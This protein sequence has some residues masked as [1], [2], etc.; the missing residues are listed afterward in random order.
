MAS[1][2]GWKVLRGSGKNLHQKRKESQP[3]ED[4]KGDAEEGEKRTEVGDEEEMRS[5]TD[6][7]GED[8]RKRRR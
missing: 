2:S 3:E 5:E 4:G 8:R 1:K 6:E 7:E